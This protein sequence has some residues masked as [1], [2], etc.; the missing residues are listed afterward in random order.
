MHIVHY[1]VLRI[2]IA[3]ALRARLKFF[4]VFL[5]PPVFKIA[6]GV[7]LASLVIK[8]VRQLMANRATGVSIIR[9]VI[10]LRI[11]QRR[12][13]HSSREVDVIHLWIEIRVH[14]CRSYVPLA[15]VYWFA[16][17]RDIA[18]VFKLRRAL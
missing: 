17:F 2:L 18:A 14:R 8:A 6:L 10:H 4:A 1:Y 15:V 16:D 13:K 12:L 7:K 9:R 11:E 3:D 5:S